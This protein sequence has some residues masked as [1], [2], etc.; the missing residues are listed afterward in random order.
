M[1]PTWFGCTSKTMTQEEFEKW[2]KNLFGD[3]DFKWRDETTNVEA[4]D[5][6]DENDKLIE[7]IPVKGYEDIPIFVKT[8]KNC[9]EMIQDGVKTNL[10]PILT[11]YETSLNLLKTFPA[12]ILAIVNPTKEM[13]DVAIAENSGL[14][15]YLDNPSEEQILNAIKNNVHYLKA[16]NPKL[17]TEKIIE[18]AV[19]IDGE[20]IQY[21]TKQTKKLQE[22]ALKSNPMAIRFIKDATA[23][24]KL[25]ALKANREVLKYL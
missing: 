20:A 14:T 19:L 2:F 8:K 23:D 16:I 15:A 7:V 18:T 4:D 25:Q 3:I 24:M 17:I 21:A 9:G 1:M 6:G 13:W 10:A 22:L 11:K 12:Y 5:N